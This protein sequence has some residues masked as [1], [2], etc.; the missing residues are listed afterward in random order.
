MTISYF[1]R[2][3]HELAYIQHRATAPPGH[4]G[5]LRLGVVFLSGLI[6]PMAG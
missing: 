5:P 1:K 2:G 6:T 3:D 4:G